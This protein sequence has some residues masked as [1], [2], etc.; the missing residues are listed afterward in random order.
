MVLD[1][2]IVGDLSI[3]ISN[4]FDTGGCSGLLVYLRVSSQNDLLLIQIEGLDDLLNR[5]WV[6]FRVFYI[7]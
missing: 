4:K 3:L 6:G 7:E 1:K 2:G 5:F